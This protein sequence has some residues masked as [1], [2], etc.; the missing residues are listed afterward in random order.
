MLSLFLF[1]LKIYRIRPRKG[2]TEILLRSYLRQILTVW[3]YKVL[4]RVYLAD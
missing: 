4:P 3:D 2:G 1:E